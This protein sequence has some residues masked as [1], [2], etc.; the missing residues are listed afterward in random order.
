MCRIS[1]L[2]DTGDKDWPLGGSY[3]AITS[4]KEMTDAGFKLGPGAIAGIVV[5]CIVVVVIIAV[6]VALVNGRRRERGAAGDEEEGEG[7]R[8]QQRRSARVHTCPASPEITIS[9]L[10]LGYVQGKDASGNSDK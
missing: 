1:G 5:A 10:D 6:A 3:R 7:E 2:C 9:D 4:A 8:G